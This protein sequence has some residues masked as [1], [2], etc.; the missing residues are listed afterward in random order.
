MFVI[1]ADQDNSRHS[2]DQVPALLAALAEF[3][4]DADGVA[5]GFERTVGDEVQ[6]VLTDAR[7]TLVIALA[8]QRRQEWSVGIGVGAASL[9][10]AETARASTGPAFLHARDAVERARGRTVPVPLALEAS[11]AA[12]AEECEALLQLLTVIVRRRSDAGW[13]AIDL[14]SAG[15]RTAKDVAEQLGISPQAVSDRLRAAMWEEERAVHPLAVRLLA[16]LD[17]ATAG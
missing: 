9:P 4:S 13:E 2:S 6:G 1:T 14:L 10:L 11:D 3:T 8:L 5:L 15:D 16:D 7:T 12:A 17:A